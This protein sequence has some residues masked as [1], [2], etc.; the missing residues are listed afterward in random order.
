MKKKSGNQFNINNYVNC[1]L[2]K[3]TNGINGYHVNQTYWITI[4]VLI[5]LKERRTEAG[6]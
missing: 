6:M 1:C 5:E 4:A 3:W 2:H